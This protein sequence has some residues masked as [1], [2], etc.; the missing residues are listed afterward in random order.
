MKRS[1]FPILVHLQPIFGALPA[2]RVCF[3]KCSILR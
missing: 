2:Q 3:Q 1:R